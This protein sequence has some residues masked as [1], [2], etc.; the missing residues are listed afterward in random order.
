VQ[1]SLL[2]SQPDAREIRFE[3]VKFLRY[4]E[5]RGDYDQVVQTFSASD[6]HGK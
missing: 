2:E 1:I 5:A 4:G 3:R 6:P